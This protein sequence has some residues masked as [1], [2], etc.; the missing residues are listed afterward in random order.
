MGISND[1]VDERL[2]GRAAQRIAKVANT[3]D[4]PQ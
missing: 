4:W 3:C 1:E 2:I